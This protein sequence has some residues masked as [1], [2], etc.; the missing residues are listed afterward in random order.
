MKTTLI[1]LL[2]AVAAVAGAAVSYAVPPTGTETVEEPSRLQQSQDFIHP[3]EGQ[4][5]ISGV[6][7]DQYRKPLPGAQVKLF[8]DGLLVASVITDAGGFYGLK[9]PIDIGKDKTV[10]LW[11]VAPG[12]HWVPKA[13]I[14]RESKAAVAAGLMSPCIPR[15]E[16]KPF[17]EFN[18]QMVDVATRNKQL[19]QSRCL[20]I[21]T[22]SRPAAKK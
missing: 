9:Y 2:I 5:S 12:T 19:A 21:S 1:G 10:V 17:L 14:L 20:G 13:V 15:V 4:T 16:V 3:I 8:V 6:L 22:G 7:S 11:Y 18:V